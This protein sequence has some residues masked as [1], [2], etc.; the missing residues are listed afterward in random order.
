MASGW[1]EDHYASQ[2]LSPHRRSRNSLMVI[3]ASSVIAGN[4]NG[5]GCSF[6]VNPVGVRVNQRVALARR[7][8]WAAG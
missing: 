3:T 5:W 4:A 2:V 1:S 6:M 8:P 7:T